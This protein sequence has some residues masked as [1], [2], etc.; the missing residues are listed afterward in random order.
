M[1]EHHRPWKRW[2]A[3]AAFAL[4]SFLFAL[5]QTLPVQAIAE[6]LEVEAA[7]AGWQ[8]RT[9]DVAPAGLVGLRMD[10]VTLESAD[11]ARIPLEQVTAKLRLLPL[12]IGRRSLDFDLRLWDGRV[13]GL[14]EQAR[15]SRRI[16]A[17]VEG[18]NLGRAAA[19]RK[20]AHVDLAGTANGDLSLALNEREPAKSTGRLDLT[21]AQAAING[22]EV[23]V[24]AMGGGALTLPR[25][26]LGTI[27]A[28]AE[29]KDGKAVFDALSAKG[30]EDLEVESE[31]FYFV[32]Q[33]R[34]AQ[35][36]LFGR[37]RLRFRDAFWQKGGTAGLRGITE[38]AL[39]PGRGPDGSYGLQLF[40]TLSNPQ[41]RP[42]P[43]PG[44]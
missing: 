12:L 16:E 32:V 8:L 14:L 36:P 3:Y 17:K 18:L 35:A 38:L 33:E 13:A 44:R 29:V 15:G 19:M 25:I 4:A 43:A 37:A 5:R 30:G 2:A 39:A 26:G 1:P 22:G 28:K 11:G 24:A 10:A 23:P 40:G 6:R 41:T 20:L 9:A 27:T 21:V 7:A 42:A 34:L 31:S